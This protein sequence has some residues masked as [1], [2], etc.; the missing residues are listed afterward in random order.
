MSNWLLI[1]VLAAFGF[2]LYRM[3]KSGGIKALFEKSRNAEQ[4]WNT[5]AL[6]MMGVV[7]FILILI[8]L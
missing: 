3:H 1:A 2:M 4:H 8:K 7:V 6:L 5:F